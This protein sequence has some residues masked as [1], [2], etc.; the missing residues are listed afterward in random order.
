M[1]PTVQ[2]TQLLKKY[3]H[4]KQGGQEVTSKLQEAQS[5][6]QQAHALLNLKPQIS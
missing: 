1:K 2:Q 5:F 4:N 6:T 3:L